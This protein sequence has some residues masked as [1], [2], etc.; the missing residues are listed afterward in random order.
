MIIKYEKR[1]MFMAKRAN[2]ESPEQ[3]VYTSNI[4]FFFLDT[5]QFSY[6]IK[7]RA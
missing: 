3:N 7:K 1:L 5:L 2:Q 4:Y 6:K